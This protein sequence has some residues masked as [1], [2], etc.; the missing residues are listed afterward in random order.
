MSHQII[1]K[2]LKLFTENFNKYF[3]SKISN[4]GEILNRAMFYSISSGGKRFRPYLVYLFGS[5]YR[6]SHKVIMELA[7][8]VEMLHNYS[9]VHD[10]L[11]SMDNDKY[12]R[13]KKTTHFKYNEFTAIL[14]GCGL[15]TQSYKILS[16]SNFKITSN[17]R[18]KIIHLLTNISG[19][20]GL[21]FGQYLD[22]SINN[23]TI[24]QR[25]EINK[26]K[27]AELMSFC[28]VAVSICAK[29]NINTE[30]ILRKIGMYIGE[31]FQINDDLSDFP[32]MTKRN[33]EILKDY[34]LKIY[35]LLLRD[36]KKINIKN[37]KLY[38]LA[39][40]LMDLKV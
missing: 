24:S 17:S 28:C 13:G 19:E 23:P 35:N 31:I 38:L 29:K 2:D 14:A 25:L 4:K 21:L 16:S 7:S 37:R 18:S 20:K 11:P 10:D 5:E 26:Y 30:R 27:T 15:L 6:L 40:Y 3:S 8:A 33:K 22:L 1:K 12:R 39:D 34:K 36:M 9:L 32:K